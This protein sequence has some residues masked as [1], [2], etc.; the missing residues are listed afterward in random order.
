LYRHLLLAVLAAGFTTASHADD[1]RR[2]NDICNAPA[3]PVVFPVVHPV[4]GDCPVDS[5]ANPYTIRCLEPGTAP[6]PASAACEFNSGV[7]HCEAWPQGD[8]LRYAWSGVAGLSS[9]PLFGSYDE[10]NP[11]LYLDCIVIGVGA[12]SLT[13]TVT[14]PNGEVATG[15]I[16]L[17]CPSRTDTHTRH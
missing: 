5:G 6:A 13:L 3:Y 7:F 1:C 11:N 14:G 9:S 15:G 16:S 2:T 8:A 10:Q 17:T 12:H 4:P